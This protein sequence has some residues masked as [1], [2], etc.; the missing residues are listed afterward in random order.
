MIKV[1]CIF[2]LLLAFSSG[3]SQKIVKYEHIKYIGFSYSGTL[4]K[5]FLNKRILFLKGADTIV[6][7]LKIPFDKKTKN[8]FDPGIFYNCQLKQDTLYS[9]ELEQSA[10]VDISKE[11]NSYY[12]TNC[13][14]TQ[15][16]GSQFREIRKDTKYSYAITGGMFIDIDHILFKIV[17]MTPASNCTMQL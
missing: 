13:L 15:A 9:F 3:R 14:F 16:K 1:T 7:N 17:K 6:F 4:N 10:V 5:S 12:K 11:L 2:M 8:I